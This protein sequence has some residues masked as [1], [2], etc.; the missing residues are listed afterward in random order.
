MEN[1]TNDTIVYKLDNSVNTEVALQNTANDVLVKLKSKF[2]G[3]YTIKANE[4]GAKEKDW[5]HEIKVRKGN[6]IGAEVSFK[7]E[8]SKPE[9]VS[10][11]VSESSK[12]GSQIALF[13]LGI[14][15]FGGALLAFNKV[16]PLAFLPGY[17]IAAVLGGFICLIPGLIVFMILKSVLL[18]NEKE[19]NNTL[20][21]E[22]RELIK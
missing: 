2:E 15:F 10:A 20:V 19:Q 8:Q 9:I 11:E 21:Q 13:T 14:F 17:K 7:W 3:E 12:L 18:K 1:D 16:E 22:V 5:T 4:F 6:K